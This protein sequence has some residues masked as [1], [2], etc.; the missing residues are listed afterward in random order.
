MGHPPRTDLDGTAGSLVNDAV[1][2]RDVL[3]M[4]YF[5]PVVVRQYWKP[6]QPGSLTTSGEGLAP[7]KGGCSSRGKDF[8]ARGPAARSDSTQPSPRCASVWASHPPTA[9]QR[10]KG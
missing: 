8:L 7:A 2:H 10:P 9:W 1:R 5:P 4:P 6:E 3:H